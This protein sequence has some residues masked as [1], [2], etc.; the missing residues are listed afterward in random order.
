[1]R[2]PVPPTP[3]TA[4]SSRQFYR[5][6]SLP[7]Y[8]L[9]VPAPLS[10]NNNN[11]SGTTVTNATSSSSSTT[12]ITQ[13]SIKSASFSTPVLTPGSTY[14]GVVTMSSAFNIVGL[15]ANLPARVRL[16]ATAASQTSDQHRPSTQAPPFEV[17]QGLICDVVMDTAPFA[18]IL[19][20]C[21]NGSNGDF[22]RTAR[23]YGTIDNVGAAAE[24]V[25]ATIQYVELVP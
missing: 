7:Q 8:R 22:P 9:L 5:G 25:S 17:T 6:H 23:V 18:W 16:Y 19:T 14:A 20:P 1:M 11:S 15:S 24:T 2:C 10:G 4:D 13:L 21:P 3:F 12:I